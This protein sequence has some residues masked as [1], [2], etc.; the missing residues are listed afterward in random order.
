LAT[1]SS[2]DFR[3]SAAGERAARALIS[4]SWSCMALAWPVGVNGAAILVAAS[5]TSFSPAGRSPISEAVLA[6]RLSGR[7]KQR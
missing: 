4:S 6:P 2:S 7:W 3:G 5:K 1:W